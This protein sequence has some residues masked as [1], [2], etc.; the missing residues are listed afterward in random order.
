MRKAGPSRVTFITALAL[1]AALVSMAL[2]GCSGGGSS[3]SNGG[4]GGGGGGGAS[5]NQLAITVNTGPALSAGTIATNSAFT[6]I[7]VC[8][9]GSTSQCQTIDGILVDT[10]SFGVRVLSS[11]LTL[12]LPQQKDASGNALGECTL[13]VSDE[14]WGP[15]QMADLSI[16]GETANGQAIQVIGGGSGNMATPPTSCSN[17]G[18]VDDTLAS[19]GANGILGVGTFISDC[20][21]GCAPGTTNN[22]GFYYSCPS[23]GCVVTTLPEANQVSNPVAA[24]AKDNNGV[25]VELPSATAPETSLSGSL[26]F[27]IGTESN[28]G[29][30]GATVY[31]VDPST[32]NFTTVFKGT[33]YSDAAFLDTGSN[34]IYFLDTTT[35]TMPTCAKP[36]DFWYCPSG[37]MNFMATNQAFQGGATTTINFSIANADTLTSNQSDGV[38]PGLGGPNPSTFDWGLPFFYGRN[39][40]IAIEGANTPGGVGPYVAY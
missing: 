11:A 40:F 30:G 10:G 1:F 32:G 35:T 23:S 18:P 27:G 5:S 22:P 8:V 17:Q 34:A 20:G 13:F 15:V 37:T 12:T 24:F 39:V 9:P 4:G 16:G 21:P 6:S 31:N 2:A 3:S 7:T 28:N 25:I 26:V 14:T 33:A 29:L 36:L 19:F 38:A